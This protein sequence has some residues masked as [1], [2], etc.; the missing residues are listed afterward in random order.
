MC[1]SEKENLNPI[2]EIK[3]E[4]L[5]KI[6]YYGNR[7]NKYSLYKK[8]SKK[9]NLNRRVFLYIINE[10]H[11]DIGSPKRFSVRNV[12]KPKKYRK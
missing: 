2:E 9:Y 7:Q 12:K 11:R 3:Q 1:E 8:F 4:Y 5:R 10:A 6:D